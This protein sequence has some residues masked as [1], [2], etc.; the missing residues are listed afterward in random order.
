MPQ[1]RF[2]LIRFSLL[3]F[4]TPPYLSLTLNCVSVLSHPVYQ[5]LQQPNHH[6][7]KKNA[8]NDAFVHRILDGGDTPTAASARHH[9]SS[10]HRVSQYSD[11]T[12]TPDASASGES[13]HAHRPASHTRFRSLWARVLRRDPSQTP[14]PSVP[15]AP[16]ASPAAEPYRLTEAPAASEERDAE[17]A[18]SDGNG[19]RY[20][21]EPGRSPSP[22]LDGRSAC[23]PS[24]SARLSPPATS[25]RER[26]SPAQASEGRREGRSWRQRGTDAARI[27]SRSPP[28]PRSQSSTAT[29]TTSLFRLIDLEFAPGEEEGEGEV[30]GEQNALLRGRRRRADPVTTESSV[31]STRRRRALGLFRYA[32][33]FIN[34]TF[35]I[36]ALLLITA[37]I[38]VHTND[39]VRFC[40]PCSRLAVATL[41]FGAVLWLLA[42]FGFVWIRER[43]ILWLLVYVGYLVLLLLALVIIVILGIVFDHDARFP[44]QDNQGLL[45]AWERAVNESYLDPPTPQAADLCAVQAAYNCSGFFFGCCAPDACYD[46]S[47]P[48][49][50]VRRVCPRCVYNDNVTNNNSSSEDEEDGSRGEVR[51]GVSRSAPDEA[52]AG[53]PAPQVCTT[54]IYTTVRKNMSGFL[55]VTGFAAVLVAAG[56][57]FAVL[58]R[59][60]D[61]VQQRPSSGVVMG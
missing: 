38:V 45:E 15:D 6:H 57:L 29:S 1:I 60:A 44:T 19:G 34:S 24:H 3:S 4:P 54:A 35:V 48:P 46:A 27:D 58:A 32:L 26:G 53:G 50:W 5:R 51:A 59:Q 33:L 61:W 7:H 9:L 30:I 11:A 36:A 23:T 20:A 13:P 21:F 41:V 37:G 43:H 16:S 10:A 17:E 14:S 52:E 28:R 2:F 8:M 40:G 25:Q 22:R 12:A 39:A 31:G 42:V 56:V 47:S 55:V 18:N 49:V